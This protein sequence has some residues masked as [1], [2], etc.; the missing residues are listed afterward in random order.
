MKTTITKTRA[1]AFA[2][3]VIISSSFTTFANNDKSKEIPAVAFRF[4]GSVEAQPVYQLD[5]SQADGEE[6]FISFSDSFGT[7]LYSGSIKN[8]STSQRFMINSDEVG[9]ETLTVTITAR[10]ANKSQVYTIK[11][12]QNLVEE[13]VIKR[14]K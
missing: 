1:I 7:V 8:G 10:K 13:N 4:I 14:I 12:S 6:Y 2:L 11:R 5:I 9:S 3:L